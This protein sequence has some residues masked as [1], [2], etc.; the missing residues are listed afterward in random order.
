[1]TARTEVSP[2]AGSGPVVGGTSVLA[3]AA[4]WDADLLKVVTEERNPSLARLRRERDPLPSDKNLS[5]ALIE[6]V[7]ARVR[8]I[9]GEWDGT[10]P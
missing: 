8:V 2:A 6:M 1:M 10:L 5:D 3:A 7:E 4:E 9:V